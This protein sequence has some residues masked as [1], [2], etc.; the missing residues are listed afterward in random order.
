MKMNLL[1]RHSMN[2]PLSDGDALKDRDG[3]F[4]DPTGKKT[5]ANQLFDF[6]KISA[7]FMLMVVMFMSMLMM[8][9]TSVSV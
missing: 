9:F 3:F 4:F 1:R 6:R 5:V 7:V 2:F 8:I